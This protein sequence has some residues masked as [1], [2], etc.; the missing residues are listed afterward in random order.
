[1]ADLGPLAP[2]YLL[3]ASAKLAAG[4]VKAVAGG[5]FFRNTQVDFVKE[6]SEYVRNR[7]I[8]VD[9]ENLKHI[10][11]GAYSAIIAQIGKWG[12]K[13]LEVM[14]ITTVCIGWTAVYDKTMH[15][16]QGNEAKAIEAADVATI[17]NSPSAR[18]QDLAEMY[19]HGEIL[20]WFTMFTSELNV[21]WN[22]LTFDMPLAMRRM[23]L[24]RGLSDIVSISIA[25]VVI[26]IASGALKGDDEEKRKKL[27][28]GLFQE[29]VDSIPLIGN[30]IFAYISGKQFQ[31][32]GVKLIPPVTM[33]M[34]TA[35]QL[36]EADWDMAVQ[37]GLQALSFTVGLPHTAGK[38]V[39][40]A[41]S[42]EYLGELLGWKKE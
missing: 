15:D 42:Q 20:K 9:L 29:Y 5:H 25:G 10:D 26:A 2:A 23:E 16:T 24:Y 8:S 28:L 1:M 4:S 30:D 37:K 27:I 7:Q 36:T 18:V 39:Y 40:R 35:R 17:R 13:G 34:D 31:A 21:I 11:P 41:I 22:R 12:M 6:R 33:W 38:R 14:D 32:S 3:E 19:R